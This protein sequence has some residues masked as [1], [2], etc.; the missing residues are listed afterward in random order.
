VSTSSPG[1]FEDDANKD[2]RAKTLLIVNY[3]ENDGLFD[4][5]AAADRPVRDPA[6]CT[7][8]STR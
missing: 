1:Q 5:R 6:M 2:V 4:P 8:P 3:D 7:S